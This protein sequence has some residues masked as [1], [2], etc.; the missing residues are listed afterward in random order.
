MLGYPLLRRRSL[1]V[2][3]TLALTAAIA[4][5]EAG[6][7]V[8]GRLAERLTN[9]GNAGQMIETARLGQVGGGIART[10]GDILV[11]DFQSTK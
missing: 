9:L 7:W 4:D 10:R 8:D 11:D 1:G 2:V 3:A 5:G 6:L